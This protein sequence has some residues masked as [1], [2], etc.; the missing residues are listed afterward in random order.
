MIENSIL[1]ADNYNWALHGMSLLAECINRLALKVFLHDKEDQYAHAFK[2]LKQL[3][4]PTDQRDNSA[5][6]KLVEDLSQ[7]KLLLDHS[8]FIKEKVPSAMNTPQPKQ[9]PPRSQQLHQG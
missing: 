1:D 9:A 3:R 4:T 6:K 5:G 7:S 2:Q 8:N